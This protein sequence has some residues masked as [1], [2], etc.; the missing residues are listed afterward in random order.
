MPHAL[1]DRELNL[2]LRKL[3][4]SQARS[5]ASHQSDPPAIP[6]NYVGMI[7]YE[8]IYPDL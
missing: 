8:K 1:K 2:T 3:E 7:K 5:N 4:P 6:N